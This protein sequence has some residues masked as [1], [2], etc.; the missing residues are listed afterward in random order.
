M[1]LTQGELEFNGEFVLIFKFH[2]ELILVH[3]HHLLFEKINQ[4][5]FWETELFL[6]FV[7]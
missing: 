1:V 4:C 3:T 5:V 7:L 6:F 2:P